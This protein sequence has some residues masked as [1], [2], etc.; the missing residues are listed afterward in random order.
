MERAQHRYS[1]ELK[2]RLVEE[3]EGGHLSLREAARDARTSV[4]MVQKWLEEDGRFKPKRDVVEVVV[5]SE[6]DRIAALE[7]ALAEAHLT[8][9]V[10][11]ELI[12]QA[13]RHYKTDFKK[14]GHPG[15]PGNAARIL[16]KK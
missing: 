16:R 2:Q 11:D 4:T 10:Y 7:Q 15:I 3:I 5:K 9:R 8:L 6:Q 13:N 1:S 12:V 14:R